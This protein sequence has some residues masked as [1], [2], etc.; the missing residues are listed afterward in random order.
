MLH[1]NMTILIELYIN[2]SFKEAKHA[3]VAFWTEY[4]QG[5]TM[6]CKDFEINRNTL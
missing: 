3:N 5:T 2:F 6:Q 1:V 4:Y